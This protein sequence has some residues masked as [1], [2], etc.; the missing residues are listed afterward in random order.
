M[1]NHRFALLPGLA[2]LCLT[3]THAYAGGE[4]WSSDFEASKKKAAEEKKDLLMDFTGS[5]WCGWCIKLNK[6]VFQEDAFKTGVKD[7]FVLVEVDF[8]KDES[9]LSEATKKQNAELQTKYAI[10]GYPTIILADATGK[11]FATTGYREGGAAGYVK[12]LDELREKK[13]KLVK[14]LADA[15]KAEGVE[16]AKQLVSALKDSGLEE[17]VIDTWY[18]D[19]VQEIKKADPKDESGFVK[20]IEQKKAFDALQEKLVPSIQGGDMEAAMKTLD[21]AAKSGTYSGKYLQIIVAT[22]ASLFAS[23]GK[24]DDAIK[25]TDEAIAVDPKGELAPQLANMKARLEEKK[26]E[27]KPKVEE[28]KE[29]PAESDKK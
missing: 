19:T 14:A 21:D 2:A 7:K 24:W 29:A 18:S 9:K 27:S 11:P 1:K 10:Q 16:K 13:G 23:Q 4:G 8:P 20:G 5:D 25:S 26:G 17:S 3:L 15:E 22:K 12:H 28:K 6:E